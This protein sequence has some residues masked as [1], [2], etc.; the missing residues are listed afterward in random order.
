MMNSSEFSIWSKVLLSKTSV[1][2][3]WAL[4][5]G[6]NLIILMDQF[7]KHLQEKYS[8][9]TVEEFEFAFRSDETVKD[10][11]RP[12]NLS[13]I[14]QVMV[15]YLS[16]RFKASEHEQKAI[17]FKMPVIVPVIEITDQE[18]IEGAR[19]SFGLTGM[20]ELISPDVFDL[21]VKEGEIKM[22]RKQKLELMESVERSVA[23][24]RKEDSD[25]SSDWAKCIDPEERLR[26]ECKKKAVA[27]YFNQLK[28]SGEKISA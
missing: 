24:R 6:N 12:V 21:L 18:L 28:S 5:E 16:K 26:N 13:L 4:P 10:W 11:G 7:K 19:Q 25:Y 2:K 14:D 3:G 27:N 20:H 15:I 23:A 1:V 17:E 8:E 9:L 22:T